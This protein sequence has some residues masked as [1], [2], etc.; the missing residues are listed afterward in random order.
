MLSH[1]GMKYVVGYDTFALFGLKTYDG[2]FHV[3]HVGHVSRQC[4]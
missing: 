3:T 2:V 4:N 1:I